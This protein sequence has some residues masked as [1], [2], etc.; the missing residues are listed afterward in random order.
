MTE[1]KI[2]EL[3][4]IGASITARCQKCLDYHI[5]K[6]KKLNCSEKEIQEA[7]KVGEKINRGSWQMMNEKIRN[8]NNFKEKK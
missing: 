4:A 1:E 2:K 5:Q 7:I 6:A 3:I 8:L